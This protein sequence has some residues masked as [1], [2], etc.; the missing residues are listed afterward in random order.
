MIRRIKGLVRRVA[1]AMLFPGML[2]QEKVALLLGAQEARRVTGLA[3]DRI[4]DAE[5]RVFSQWGDDGIIQYLIDRVPIGDRSFIE[6]GVEDY[7]ESN[8]RFLLQNN[9]WRGLILDGGTAHIDFTTRRGLRWRHAL[10]VKSLFVTRDNINQALEESGRTGDIGLLSIDVDGND[11]WIWEAIHA[12]V[13][14]IVVVEYNSSF[15]PDLAVS[16]PYQADFRRFQKHYSGLYWGASLAAL[17]QLG[18]RKRYRFVGCN[19]AGNNAYFVLDQVAGPLPRLTPR[20]GYVESQFRESRDRQ[21]RLTYLT[22]RDERIREIADLPV[23]ELPS[24]RIA[25]IR[26]LFSF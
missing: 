13:P 20:D 26:E 10:D 15:G 16:V 12:V 3:L 6:F 24:T 1:E 21:G 17:C 4:Q 19:S 2:E 11:Y 23:V 9:R 25:T 7:S 5:F 14:R 22:T 8:T 18:A